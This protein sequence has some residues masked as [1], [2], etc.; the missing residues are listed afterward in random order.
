MRVAELIDRLSKVPD[1]YD[2]VLRVGVLD[3]LDDPIEVDSD[4][5]I[6]EIGEAG[7]VVIS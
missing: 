1:Y 3:Y 5:T 7:S 2:V 4:P 6:V